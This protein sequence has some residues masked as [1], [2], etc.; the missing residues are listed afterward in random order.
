MF[1]SGAL[2]LDEALP[3]VYGIVA[4]D[5]LGCVRTDSLEVVEPDSLVSSLSYAYFGISDSAQVDL[6][7][8]GG[9]PPYS[10]MWSGPIDEA[11]GV[12]APVSLGWLVE[13]ANGCLD[14]GVVE[15]APTRWRMFPMLN[16]HLGVACG[17]KRASG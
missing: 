12:L 11:G 1:D 14:L 9:T 15:I 3:G 2:V 10:I 8:D 17:M 5:S 13:D 4:T 6:L 7:V 16:P